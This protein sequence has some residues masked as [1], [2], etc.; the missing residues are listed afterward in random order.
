MQT[1]IGRSVSKD[2]KAA[3]AEATKGLNNPHL[4]IFF[5]HYDMLKDVTEGLKEA[6]PNVPTIG[7]CAIS[8]YEKDASDNK[9]MVIGFG[10]DAKVKVGVL[11]YLST[12]PLYDIMGLKSAVNEVA[13]GDED[14]ICFELCTNDEERLVTTMNVILGEK[15]API[16]GGTV[17]GVPNGKTAYVA[18]DGVLYEDA[19]CYAVIKNTTGKIRTYSEHIYR[20]KE[21]AKRHIAT[22]VN[23]KT[24]ELVQMDYKPASEVY[25]NELGLAR[26]Q[27]VD[28]VLENPLG[29]IIGDEVYICS[30]YGIGEN[31][32]LIN[33]KRFNENDTVA[34][35][36]LQ[37]Y[38]AINGET[39]RKIKS[40]NS[41]IS[42]VLSINCIYRHL[43]FSQRNHLQDFMDDMGT[44]GKHVGIVG[45]G[46][47]YKTQHVNQTMVCAVFS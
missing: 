4:I 45:G 28:N 39:R 18:V 8:Y 35:L 3:V 29:R 5:S 42:F 9:L 30:Q 12:A 24:K 19:C 16:I 10:S 14:S 36:Q 47:Q 25:G 38:E 6:F 23:M 32:S 21:N 27:I 11:R 22:K 7:S 17:F 40:E 1:F 46:E 2:A 34:I 31:G 26:N 20:L 43:L 41:N 33:Y 44:L 13:P 15:K 37:D